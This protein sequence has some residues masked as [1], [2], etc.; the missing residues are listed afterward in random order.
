MKPN[1]LEIINLELLKYPRTTHLEGSRLQAGDEGD[2]QLP[3]TSLAG[4]YIVVEEKLDGG[5]AGLSFSAG[6][7]L[8]LQSR[9]HYLTGGGRERQFNLYKQWA[10]AHEH[11]LINVLDDRYVMFGEWMHKK[12][13]MFYNTLPHYFLEFDIWDRAKQCFLSTPARQQLLY[14][15]PVLAVPVL[16]AGIAPHKLSDLIALLQPSLARH[17]GWQQVF[18]QQVQ[19]ERLE[20]AKAWQ[21]TDRSELAEGLYIKVEEAGQ[22]VARYKW[23]RPD[24]VQAILESAVHHAEQPFIANQLATGVDLFAPSLTHAWPT[25]SQVTIPVKPAGRTS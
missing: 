15:L 16:Y 4:R 22:T 3:Y 6:G 14:G 18:E 25:T 12:H 11:R 19:R 5:N 23:V 8:L 21:Q 20:L 17:T 10:V 1:S 9:G 2:N 7:E 13:A 24:F